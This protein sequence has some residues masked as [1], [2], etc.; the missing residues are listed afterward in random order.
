M[1]V[2]VPEFVLIMVV[3]TP[4]YQPNLDFEDHDWEESRGMGYSYGYNREEDAWDYNSPIFDN[5]IN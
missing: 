4:E 3:F 1:I 5:C 2:G